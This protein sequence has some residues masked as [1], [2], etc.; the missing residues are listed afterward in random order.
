VSTLRVRRAGGVAGLLLAGLATLA[1][2]IPAAAGEPVGDSAWVVVRRPAAASYTVP[3]ADRRSTGGGPVTVMRAGTG[4]W[5]IDLPGIGVIG[6][7]V[8]HAQA[9]PMGSAPAACWVDSWGGTGSFDH[10]VTVRCVDLS[11]ASLDTRFAVAWV[12]DETY[13]TSLPYVGYAWNHDPSASGTPVSHFQ[14][15]SLGGTITVVRS[16]TGRHVF[17][18]PGATE[19]G[20]VAVG[21]FMEAAACRVVGWAPASGN[22]QVDVLCRSLDGTTDVDRGVLLYASDGAP[23]TGLGRTGTYLLAAEPSTERYVPSADHAWSSAGRLPLILRTGRG[24]Y[25]IRMRDHLP[26]GAAIVTAYGE[27]TATCQLA[28]LP[29]TT[30]ARALVRCFS[31]AGTTVDAPFTLSWVR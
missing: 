26:G 30:P 27:G 22:T 19:T 29:R 3:R 14:H 12:R 24:R 15:L 18:I 2:V 9:T 4:Y 5:R 1:S 13:D 16:A 23:I 25:E 20:Y 21:P 17:T 8:G 31:P 28:A 6:G 7:N 10:Y 11:G